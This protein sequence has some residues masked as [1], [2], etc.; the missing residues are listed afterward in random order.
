[1]TISTL[2][3]LPDASVDSPGSFSSKSDSFFGAL[4]TLVSEIN[5]ANTA[6]EDAAAGSD[7][8]VNTVEAYKNVTTSPSVSTTSSTTI[9]PAASAKTLTIPA[10][11]SFS[12][13]MYVMVVDT[14]N[15][16]TNWMHG[17]ITTHTTGGT[18]MTV[19]GDLTS[20]SVASGSSWRIV[21]SGPLRFLDTNA[22]SSSTVTPAASSKTFTTQ[23]GKGFS[24]GMYV[25]IAQTG[26]ESTN[27]MHGVVTS[28]LGTTLVV[29]GTSTSANVAS[30][31]SWQISMSAAPQ[32]QNSLG[33]NQTWQTPTRSAGTVYQNT[34]S[35][36]IYVAVTA[37]VVVGDTGK[38]E[39]IISQSSNPTTPVV[40]QATFGGR[41]G[42]AYETI[43]G[44]VQPGFYYKVVL[45][46]STKH[47]WYELR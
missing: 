3:V 46:T 41:I 35:K 33:V 31:A 37:K 29:T 43:Q 2:P 19:T 27:W 30:A 18:S 34:T 10:G 28:Y 40:A 22:T 6:I 32:A 7:A 14:A 17:M 13:G 20:N 36:P 11:T 16:S 25:M 39:L 15:P 21:L 5:A 1:M 44:V 42:D 47:Q 38:A 4:P 23:A 12:V 9:T 24:P 45:T 8:D 26:A